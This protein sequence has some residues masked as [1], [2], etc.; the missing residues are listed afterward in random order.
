M[1]FSAGQ[2]LEY[3][4]GAAILAGLGYSG[5]LLVQSKQASDA[6]AANASAQQNAVVQAQNDW[7][8][9][10]DAE[11]NA[12]YAAAGTGVEINDGVSLGT[13]TMPPAFTGAGLVTPQTG[14]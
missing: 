10:F 13:L 8:N 3:A 11:Q 5:Y 9:I 1:A 14:G 7:Q 6:A 12:S 4:A 2:A